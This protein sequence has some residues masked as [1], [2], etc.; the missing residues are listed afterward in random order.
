[1]MKKKICLLGTAAVLALTVCAC[2]KEADTDDTV[3]VTIVNEKNTLEASE[4]SNLSSGSTVKLNYTYEDLGGTICVYEDGQVYQELTVPDWQI[5]E[6]LGKNYNYLAVKDV[7]FDGYEDLV[8]MHTL[9][10]INAYY[11]AFLYHSESNTFEACPEYVEMA[12][13]ELS[14]DEKMIVAT[15]RTGAYTYVVTSYSWDGYTLVQEECLEVGVGDESGIYTQPEYTGEVTEDTISGEYVLGDVT[16]GIIIYGSTKDG[17]DGEFMAMG[18]NG[19]GVHVDTWGDLK[20]MGDNIYFSG[21]DDAGI[22][23]TFTEGCVQ[24]IDSRQLDGT[25]KADLN[26]MY[27]K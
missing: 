14:P 12:N 20:S 15:D 27:W 23:F 21:T 24:I 26:G 18:T 10:E 8:Y 2:S 17:V 11:Y 19:Q 1:M 9:G 7:N 3:G 22:V 25:S 13:P 6:T 5:S 4:D 16:V